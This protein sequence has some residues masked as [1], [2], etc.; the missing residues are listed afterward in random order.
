[1]IHVPYNGGAAAQ[2]DLLP[3]RVDFMFDSSSLPNIGAGRV[4]A[5]AVGTE[6]RSKLLPEVPTLSEAGI[7]DFR[8]VTWFGLYAPMTG[9]H[10]P[11]CVP[12]LAADVQAVMQEPEIQEKLF[13]QGAEPVGSSPQEMQRWAN[14][15]YARWS[16]VVKR[17][18]ITIGK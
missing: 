4:R 9:G 15:E 11:A 1:M 6:T 3:G 8:S 12:K 16:A 18:N 13:A 7:K 14:D 2:K 10:V 5:L 17:A